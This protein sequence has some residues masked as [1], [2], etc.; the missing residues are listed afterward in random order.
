MACS[1]NEFKDEEAMLQAHEW[2]ITAFTV[3]PAWAHPQDGRQIT[4]MLAEAEACSLDDFFE[5]QAAG[6][7]VHHRGP[8]RCFTDEPASSST[9]WQLS[10][11]RDKLW[12]SIAG[13]P[14]YE[15]ELQQL[16]SGQMTWFVQ[17]LPITDSVFRNATLVL[18]KH[19]P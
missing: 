2:S 16:I 4:D 19:N 14:Y 10:R 1:K 9:S 8:E 15:V 12:L 6:I 17:A 11:N 3:E 7:F 18:Q 13:T 5:F